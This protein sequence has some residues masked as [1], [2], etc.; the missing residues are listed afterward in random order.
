[1]QSQIPFGIFLG[2]GAILALLF[3][4]QMIGWY[5]ETFIPS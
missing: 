3:G 1:M 4:D 2:I 5:I